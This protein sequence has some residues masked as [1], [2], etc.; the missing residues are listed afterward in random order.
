MAI[1]IL[2]S[3]RTGTLTNDGISTARTTTPTR[4]PGLGTRPISRSIR[5]APRSS[6]T[7]ADIVTSKLLSG[8]GQSFRVAFAKLDVT[9]QAF[10]RGQGS[11]LAQQGSVNV[12]RHDAMRST[13]V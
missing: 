10:L 6:I 11:G 2:S 13:S 5:S 1:F 4:P 12:D 7:V 9:C 3:A 8:K